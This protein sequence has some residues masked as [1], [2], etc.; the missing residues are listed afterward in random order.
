MKASGQ[1]H[2][3]AALPSGQVRTEQ[4]TEWAPARVL[5]N[6]NKEKPLPHA[7]SRTLDPLMPNVY[8]A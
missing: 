6:W 8:T 1:H 5:T 4:E 2:A 3:P 7:G